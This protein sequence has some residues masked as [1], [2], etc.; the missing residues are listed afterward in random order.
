MWRRFLFLVR[1]GR[2]EERDRTEACFETIVNEEDTSCGR[3]AVVSVEVRADTEVGV[4]VCFL[5][6][7]RVDMGASVGMIEAEIIGGDGER[8]RD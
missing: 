1:W 4:P 8:S 7:V 6:L 3:S 2:S 5:D